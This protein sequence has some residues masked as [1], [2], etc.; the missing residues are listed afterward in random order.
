MWPPFSPE[1]VIEEFAKLLRSYRITSIR[2]DRY[3]GEFPREQFRKHGINYEPAE[4][5]KSELY[6]DLVPTINSGAVDLLDH[7]KLISQLIGLE[8]R[9]RSGGRDQI[10]HA[11]GGHDDIANAVAGA[12]LVSNTAVPTNFHRRI[13]APRL[14]IV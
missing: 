12:V 6:G 5:T 13:E 14:G 11:P 8:R 9:A 10:D 7:P 4:R 3:A 2:G 1:A